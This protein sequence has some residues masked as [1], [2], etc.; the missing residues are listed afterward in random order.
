MPAGAGLEDPES[1]SSHVVGEGERVERVGEGG[2]GGWK[3]MIEVRQGG[4]Y[5]AYTRGM[6]TL[7]FYL[8]F[9]SRLFILNSVSFFFLFC[10]FLP[11][12]WDPHAA[13][14]WWR[15]GR[16]FPAR[17]GCKYMY[18]ESYEGGAAHSSDLEPEAL[19]H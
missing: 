12:S 8:Y 14:A 13:S 3:G 9:E 1:H 2:G 18:V 16:L 15:E 6:M 4:L 10:F 11:F 17:E 19:K 7:S 5:R